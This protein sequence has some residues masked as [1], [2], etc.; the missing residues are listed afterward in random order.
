[1]GCKATIRTRTSFLRQELIL[2]SSHSGYYC[3]K[4]TR[5]A[6][7]FPCP[8]G[9]YSEVSGATDISTCLP[10]PPGRFC[11]RPGLV[12]PEGYCAPGWFCP[13][14]SVSNK[15]AHLS[16]LP[17]RTNSSSVS[18]NGGMCPAGAFCP[19]G[20][21]YP[22][23]CT[24]GKYC[25]SRELSAESGRCEA[26][27]YCTRGSS[28]PNPQSSE[29]GDVCPPGHFCEAGTSTPSPCPPGT[30]MPRPSA[31]S[32]QD[33]LPCTAGYYCPHWGSVEPADRCSDGWFCPAGTVHPQSP[34]NLCPVGHYCPAGSSEPMTCPVGYYQEVAGQSQCQVCPA[35][36]YCGPGE[37]LDGVERGVY[38]PRD[39]PA[40]YYCV[41]G[42]EFGQQ[43]PCP[44]GT[45]SD[46]TGLI[47]SAGCS[48]CPGGWFC[49]QL[50]TAATLSD[51]SP[52]SAGLSVVLSVLR[53]WK[54]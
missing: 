4:K 36:R 47:S 32:S 14:G 54:E 7:Q 41:Q 9:T 15:P 10:C 26:G 45:Y 35:G 46:R 25:A 22:V 6:E 30:Y 13:A 2:R 44:A 18:L 37:D 33:C 5:Y 24:P 48:P 38:M 12:E 16:D 51:C 23:P 40:G 50:G 42:T 27:F 19:E 49:A 28:V 8:P 20:S 31:R 52:D 29:A 53:V 43:H 3:P 11:S 21:P 39:C 34:E 1:M 17:G